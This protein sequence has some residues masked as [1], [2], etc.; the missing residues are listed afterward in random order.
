M[1]NAEW[2]IDRPPTEADGDHIGSVH[3]KMHPRGGSFCRIYW[4]YVAAGAPWQHTNHW[5][6][7]AEPTTAK[8]SLINCRWDGPPPSPHAS[9]SD[10]F[11]QEGSK[12]ILHGLRISA[13]ASRGG[14]TDVFDSPGP[15]PTVSRRGLEPLIAALEQ[16]LKEHIR[17][18]SVLAAALVKR[19]EALEGLPPDGAIPEGGRGVPGGIAALVKRLEELE[20]VAEL[21][22]GL[23]DLELRVAE[24]ERGDD[25]VGLL[26]SHLQSRLAKLEGAQDDGSAPKWT[27]NRIADLQDQL[28]ALE[29][30]MRQLLHGSRF[31]L[32]VEPR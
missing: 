6:P 9:V 26:Y 19:L 14:D 28:A 23:P 24:L 4:S 8:A 31:R 7:P 29:A 27:L 17:A 2:I 18:Q 5:Q 21:P 11:E 10:W 16:Q 1:S 32:V 13:L 25:A 15:A 20:G 3:V 22:G 30:T 12:G